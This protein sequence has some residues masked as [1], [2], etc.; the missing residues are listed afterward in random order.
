M[1]YDE[2]IGKEYEP[3]SIEVEKGRLRLFA[4]AAGIE[5]PVYSNEQAAL[6]AGYSSLPAPPTFAYSVTMDAGQSFN[7]LE[8]M[9]IELSRAVHGGQSFRYHKA[10]CA[11]DVISG[12]QLIKNI[13][14]KK[15][16]ALLFIETA[17]QL[18]NQHG[19]VVSDLASTIIVR[20]G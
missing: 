15:G 14:E 19:E 1:S 20:N 5:D 9:G 11:G 2:F 4:K 6:D 16:G 18:K 17:F 13:S 10:I 3:F 8:D 7:V 12:H